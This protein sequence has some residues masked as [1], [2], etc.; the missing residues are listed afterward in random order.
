MSSIKPELRL[1]V[2]AGPNGSG[3]STIIGAVRNHKVSEI[4]VDFGT[5]INTDDLAKQLLKEEIDF[6]SYTIE[7]TLEEFT[8]ICTLSGLISSAFTKDDFLKTFSLG[9]KQRKK[10]ITQNQAENRPGFVK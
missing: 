6:N 9:L 3:K 1:R 10:F 7:T 8:E 4:P 5:Y 2:F